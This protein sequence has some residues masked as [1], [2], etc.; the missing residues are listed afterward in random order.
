MTQHPEIS[1]ATMNDLTLTLH[2]KYDYS[3]HVDRVLASKSTVANHKPT[4][5]LNLPATKF[6]GIGPKKSLDQ[7]IDFINENR[8]LA[9]RINTVNHRIEDIGSRGL[10]L[11]VKRS[12]KM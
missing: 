3:L 5:F 8:T 10:D 6:Y 9:S 1:Y 4:M 7:T 2:K 12:F 11:S